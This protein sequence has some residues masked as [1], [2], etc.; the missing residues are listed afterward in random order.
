MSSKPTPSAPRKDDGPTPVQQGLEHARRAVKSGVKLGRKH[1]PVV[2]RKT[3]AGLQH[4]GAAIRESKHTRKIA[5]TGRKAGKAAGRAVK[6]KVEKYPWLATA[7]QRVSKT[8]ARVT[9]ATHEHLVEKRYFEK[10]LKALDEQVRRYPAIE[11]A[12]KQTRHAFSMGPE[13]SL[14]KTG[15]T[16]AKRRTV[17]K[18]TTARKEFYG[19]KQLFRYGVSPGGYIL[20]SPIADVQPPRG[21]DT[22][23]HDRVMPP[24]EVGKLIEAALQS[25]GRYKGNM[26]AEWIAVTYLTFARKSESMR[27]KWDDIDYETATVRI[28]ND[29][30]GRQHTKTAAE[31]LVPMVPLLRSVFSSLPRHV[32]TPNVFFRRDG[33][34]WRQPIPT[35]KFPAARH[36]RGQSGGGERNGRTIPD[37]DRSP[38]DGKWW[39]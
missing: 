26:L 20:R 27:L 4:A 5:Q 25:V 9:K 12:W 15:T 28:I 29:P 3:A 31:R 17:T 1:G 38:T 14:D 30:A 35:V 19:I 22:V 13:S 23:P 7:V 37:G 8:T 21:D 39:Q 24:R 2:A 16:A 11:N 6:D 36:Q 34:A 32:T 18:K 10:S 33:S